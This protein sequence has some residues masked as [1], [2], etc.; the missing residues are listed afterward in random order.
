MHGAN[1]SIT[2]EDGKR[3]S[4]LAIDQNVLKLF[5]KYDAIIYDIDE[6]LSNVEAQIFGRIDP[7]SEMLLSSLATDLE[8]TTNMLLGEEGLENLLRLV[9]TQ[10][11]IKGTVHLQG[12]LIINSRKYF[13]ALNP[14]E[15]T[16]V[17]Y[18]S[19]EDYPNKPKKILSLTK[20]FSI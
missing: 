5:E 17:R 12:G 20:I 18:S 8:A 10:V 11:K 1:N 6:E 7:E 9:Q 14:L 13:Y 3:P 15:G 2:N 19:H 4:D 16:F